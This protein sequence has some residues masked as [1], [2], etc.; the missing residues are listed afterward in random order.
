MAIPPVRIV[1]SAFTP[2]VRSS[3]YASFWTSR[4]SWPAT[5]SPPSSAPGSALIVSRAK[6]RPFIDTRS[7]GPAMAW[8]QSSGRCSLV[9][10]M[11]TGKEAGTPSVRGTQAALALVHQLI[12]SAPS[13]VVALLTCG[14]VK[15]T[16]RASHAHANLQGGETHGQD[17]R[18][19]P[20]QIKC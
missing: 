7:R 3:M 19:Q 8:V 6:I 17:A 2:A 4:S 15:P 1:D 13:I 5:L 18:N 11:L 10:L 14:T 16:A 20:T 9:G 12:E